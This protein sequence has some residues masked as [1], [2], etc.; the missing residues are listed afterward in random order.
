MGIVPEGPRVRPDSTLPHCGRGG[1][2]SRTLPLKIG[3]SA[4]IGKSGGTRHDE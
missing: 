3:T 1:H 4:G 2:R